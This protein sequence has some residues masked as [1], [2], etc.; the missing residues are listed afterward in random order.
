[1][2]MVLATPCGAGSPS[3]LAIAGAMTAGASSP[4]RGRMSLPMQAT[5]AALIS[6]SISG[7]VSSTTTNLSTVAAKALIFSIGSG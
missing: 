4:W 1:M 7:S 6:V 5:P 3:S 2:G